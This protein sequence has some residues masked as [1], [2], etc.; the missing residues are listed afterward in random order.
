MSKQF[1]FPT[2]THQQ[3]AETIVDFFSDR[4]QAQAVVLVNSCARGTATPESDLDIAI[5]VDPGLSSDS[6]QSLEREWLEY[7][8]SHP[9]FTQLKQLG[10]FSGVH[11]DLFDGCWTAERWDEGGEPDSFEI[12]IGN[13]VA[14]AV[15]IWERSSAFAELRAAWLPYYRDALQRE[16]LQMVRESCQ[17]NIAHLQFY[18]NRG[19]YFQAFDRLNHAF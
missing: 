3:T 10:R 8:E 11:L 16:R 15:P 17:L 5:L 7:H 12:E 6:R 1:A 13:R 2:P 14:Y 4:A 19:E 9:I 18:V